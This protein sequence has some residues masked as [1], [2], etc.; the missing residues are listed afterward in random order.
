MT[1]QTRSKSALKR[2][3]IVNPSFAKP[4]VSR[5]ISTGEELGILANISGAA[6]LKNLTIH[7]EI[8]KPGRRSSPPHYHSIKEE[9]VYVVSGNPS[10]CIDGKHRQLSPG[11]F[12]G[13]PASVPRFHMI[14]NYHDMDAVLIV[15]SVDSDAD[16]VSFEPEE[17]LEL[18]F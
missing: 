10:V 9:I 18:L 12:V 5:R 3:G 13:F 7:Q 14:A 8:L 17:Q 15:I 6:N 4:I 2:F 1:A 16:T 11:E